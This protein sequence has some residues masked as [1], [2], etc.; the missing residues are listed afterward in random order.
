[1][2]SFAKK[3]DRQGAQLFHDVGQDAYPERA[4]PDRGWSMWV[5][6][7]AG[8]CNMKYRKK[9]KEVRGPTWT[10]SLFSLTPGLPCRREKARGM[11]SYGLVMVPSIL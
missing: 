1:M 11:A 6:D 4:D 2:L 3:R 7:G 5:N 8:L 10:L 9:F